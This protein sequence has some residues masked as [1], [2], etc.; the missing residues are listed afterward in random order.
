MAYVLYIVLRLSWE[1]ACARA[2]ADTRRMASWKPLPRRCFISLT[3]QLRTVRGTSG[4]N[5]SPTE[6]FCIS[7]TTYEPLRSAFIRSSRLRDL[8]FK[9]S[10][11]NHEF[12]FFLSETH[13]SLKFCIHGLS[14]TVVT[15]LYTGPVNIKFKRPVEFVCAFRFKQEHKFRS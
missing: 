2:C 15:K 3:Q 13:N 12:V 6:T 1:C 7:R 11:R 4:T 8:Q 10:L 5:Q 14:S 9:I